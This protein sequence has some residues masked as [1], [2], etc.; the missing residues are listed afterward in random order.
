M[1]LISEM[2]E[3][4]TA[5]PTVL[6]A[7]S[8]DTEGPEVVIRPRSGWIPVDWGEMV[9]GRELLYSLIGRDVKVRYKQTVLGSAW[10]ILQPLLM[11]SIFT[12]VFGR[13]VRVPSQGIVYPVFV[14]AGLVL[15]TFFSNGVNTASQSLINHQYLLTK[16]YFPRLYVPTATVGALLVDLAIALAIFF[17]TMA[18]YGV[19]P[20]WQAPALIPLLGL[21]ILATL[22]LGYAGAALT[23]VYRDV[24]YLVTFA[25]QVLMYLSPVIYPPE[26]V[27]ARLHPILA[28][29]PAFGLIDACRS[30]VLGTPWHPGPLAISTASALV[31]F[32]FGLFYFRRTERRFADIV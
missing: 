18:F 24:R 17:A 20:S 21:I 13:F 27:P 10:A 16:V 19:R 22:G 12:M 25:L 29:N 26:M 2:T 9:R 32:V 6:V 15:W 28:L 4:A 30:A 3:S 23:V 5:A 14:L 7:D 8:D 31:L 1:N 11:T